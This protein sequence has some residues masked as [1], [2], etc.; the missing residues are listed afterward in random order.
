MTQDEFDQALREAETFV[1]SFPGMRRAQ[2]I[3]SGSYLPADQ[4]NDVDFAMLVSG[5]R[6]MDSIERMWHDGWKD[7]GDY[8]TTDQFEW[9]ALR[10]RNANVMVTRSQ[11]FF[12][13][14]LLA[15]EVCKVLRLTEK[16]QRIAVCKVVRDGILAADY[17]SFLPPLAHANVIIGSY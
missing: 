16:S 7:C 3:G 10:R 4:C 5:D 13:G 2:L 1:R 12:D 9:C 15:T 14:Y 11:K 17:D 6:L 8:D